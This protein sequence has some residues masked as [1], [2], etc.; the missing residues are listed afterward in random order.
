MVLAQ[1]RA[2]QTFC[3]SEVARRLAD[4]WRPL[5]DA[6]RYEAGALQDEGMIEA[7]QKGV[8]ADPRTAVGPIRLRLSRDDSGA[9]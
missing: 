7:S 8:P 2:P 5:M 9:Q 3:P 4:D 1:G 6:V